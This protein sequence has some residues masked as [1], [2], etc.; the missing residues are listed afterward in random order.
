MSTASAL[1]DDG[2]S[3]LDGLAAGAVNTVNGLAENLSDSGNVLV[4]NVVES[5]DGLITAVGDTVGLDGNGGLVGAAGTALGGIGSATGINGLVNGVIGAADGA[6]AGDLGASTG[7][8]GAS[9]SIVANLTDDGGVG[10]LIS[11]AGDMAA[12]DF[13]GTGVTDGDGQIAS[14]SLLPNGNAIL[15]NGASATLNDPAQSGALIEAD[16]A[17]NGQDDSSTSLIN[18]EAG[19]ESQSPGVVANVFSDSADGSRSQTDGNIIDLGPD[20]QT[21]AD[22]NVAT[23]P[24]QFQF[25]SLDGT[26]RIRWSARWRMAGAGGCRRRSAASYSAGHR[27]RWPASRR[28]RDKRGR[29]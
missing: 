5:A 6:F 24:D 10:D 19:P 13:A 7:P 17:S 26:G 14:A 1:V 12:T 11:D 23:A 21:L 2:V 3:A 22:A 16:A 27:P 29:G 28:C 25:A 15:D 9:P 8:D 4:G 18:A 20:G